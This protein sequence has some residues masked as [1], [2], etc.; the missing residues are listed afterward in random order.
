MRHCSSGGKHRLARRE[1]LLQAATAGDDLYISGHCKYAIYRYEQCGCAS[2]SEGV[3]SSGTGA[4]SAEGEGQG[5]CC[6]A[7][8]RHAERFTTGSDS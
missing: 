1:G 6:S 7:Q 4:S 2:S 8:R 3:S 5:G